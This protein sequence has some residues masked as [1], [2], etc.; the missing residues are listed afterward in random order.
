MSA[1]V[2][3]AAAALAYATLNDP[4]QP[5]P[6]FAPERHAAYLK[7]VAADAGAEPPTKRRKAET[8]HATW[9]AAWAD[10]KAATE[11]DS[12]RT[13]VAA[14]ARRVAPP[15]R[16]PFSQGAADVGAPGAAAGAGG[17]AHADAARG[18]GGG[19]VRRRRRRDFPASRRQ[20]DR[21]Q[22]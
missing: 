19:V 14:A 21:K 20:P 4:T 1:A 10:Y 6:P 9:R 3:E 11:G 18:D 5:P 2:D 7:R 8:V 13:Q 17:A 15:Q 12:D 22:T 16:R